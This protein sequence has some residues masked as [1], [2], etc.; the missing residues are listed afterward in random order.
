[1]LD[2][3]EVRLSAIGV[4]LVVLLAMFVLYG[5]GAGQPAGP[6]L[7]T[8]DVAEDPSEHV[9]ERVETGGTV[10][11]EDPVVIEAEYEGGTVEFEVENAPSVDVGEELLL[12]GEL[13]DERT[14]DAEPEPTVVREPWERAYMYTISV[15]GVGLVALRLANEWR[16]AAS[17]F[18]FEPRDRTL[19]DRYVRAEAG[20]AEQVG[21][22]S[23]G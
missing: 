4:L 7:G 10:V 5:A 3:P 17:R 15:V 14:V 22:K 8:E 6:P 21:G 23:D 11:Q 1:M 16:F 13:T 9:G 19:Y 12:V 18:V 20:S 2:R